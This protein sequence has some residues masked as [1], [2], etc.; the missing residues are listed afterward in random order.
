MQVSSS[1][2]SLNWSQWENFPGSYYIDVA[3]KAIQDLGKMLL[4]YVKSFMAKKLSAPGSSASDGVLLSPVLSSSG[5]SKSEQTAID[6]LNF[7]ATGPI[8]TTESP[9]AL[10][11]SRS[12]S[13]EGIA[14]RKLSIRR[15]VTPE[16]G[17][18]P[19]IPGYIVEGIERILEDL[20]DYLQRSA[21]GTGV[22]SEKVFHFMVEGEIVAKVIQNLGDTNTT[23]SLIDQFECAQKHLRKALEKSEAIEFGLAEKVIR[24]DVVS[25]ELISYTRGTS[26]RF[27]ENRGELSHIPVAIDLLSRPIEGVSVNLGGWVDQS[28]SIRGMEDCL[29]AG[30]TPLL[31]LTRRNK[32]FYR[33]ICDVCEVLDIS[34]RQTQLA[35]KIIWTAECLK[36]KHARLSA[37][38]VEQREEIARLREENSLL[39]EGNQKLSL[40]NMHIYGELSAYFKSIKD[41][42][43]VVS[44]SS[45]IETSSME[46]GAVASDS[47]PSFRATHRRWS[48][49][50][51]LA[52]VPSSSLI[53]ASS[54]ENGSAA[55]DAAPSLRLIT[56]RHSESDLHNLI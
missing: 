11:C 9:A 49:S 46:D 39:R 33:I 6:A 41:Q 30:F 45:L 15:P 13:S 29:T 21:K 12:C 7:N 28:E 10:S 38:Y 51:L 26:F 40:A 53:E 16:E 5:I 34:P 1:V 55:S 35:D 22:E 17:I 42:L 27:N 19:V 8:S 48:E 32:S 18:E 43:P 20:S 25:L 50:A 44:S 54:E 47:I 2:V 14:V 52:V 4:S 37:G 3:I 31:M 56:R 23:Q 36:T 24:L